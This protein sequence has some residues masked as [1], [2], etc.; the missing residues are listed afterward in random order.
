MANAITTGATA[1]DTFNNLNNPLN[2]LNVGARH[3]ARGD[4]T[5][6]FD[7]DYI[8]LVAQPTA[9]D[10][11]APRGSMLLVPDEDVAINT[12]VGTVHVGKGAVVLL[13]VQPNAGVSIYDLHDNHV[14]DVSISI[15]GGTPTTLSPGRHLSVATG[16]ADDFAAI[17]PFDT[18][19]HRQLATKKIGALTVFTSE[20]SI[21]S[22]MRNLLVIAAMTKSH[23]PQHVRITEAM[24][25]NAAILMQLNGA[26]EP[27]QRFGSQRPKSKLALTD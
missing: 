25:K 7:P 2:H 17:N 22:A 3:A 5:Q 21:P 1:N 4:E 15:D 18:V 27:Y 8:A 19:S 12:A 14:G 13:V 9:A 24:L 16:S 10:A 23:K 6:A 26:A 20:F 11:T